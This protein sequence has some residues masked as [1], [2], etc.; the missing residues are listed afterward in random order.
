MLSDI[1]LVGLQFEP[2][3]LAGFGLDMKFLAQEGESAIV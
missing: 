3:V 2:A 1:D